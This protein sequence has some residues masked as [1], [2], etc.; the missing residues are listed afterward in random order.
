M[1]KKRFT[2]HFVVALLIVSTPIRAQDGLFISEVTDPADD[3]SGR[4]IELYNAGSEAVDFS[5]TTLYLSR[6]SNGGT[7][8][9]DLQLTG[10]IAAGE[11]FVIGGSAF[12]AVYGFAPNQETGILIGNGDDAYFL[13]LD[14]DHESGTLHDIYGL[15]DTDGSGEPWEYE[16]SRA[17]RAPA[18][19]VPNTTWTAAEWEIA[20]A[21]VAD[22]DP[23]SHHG[24]G[25][26]GPHTALTIINDTA[27]VGEPV[28]VIVSAD[29]LKATDNIISYQFDVHFNHS[30]LEYTGSQISGTL[31]EG[32]TVVVNTNIAG[33]LSVSY[34]NSAPLIGEGG[35]LKLLFNTLAP[36]TTHISLVNAY[37][38]NNPVQEI[39][40]GTVV[41]K[42]IIPPTA[43]ITYNDSIHRFAD[44]LLITATFSQPM[45]EDYVVQIS[46]SGAASLTD[47]GMIRQ[48]ETSYTYPYSIPKSEGEVLVRLGN[49]TDLWG[50]PLV[51]FPQVVTL[52]L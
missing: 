8:W 3:Y 45:S 33:S 38:N 22:C 40:N 36:D 52:F 14:G 50:N 7:G 20:F 44:T 1:M 18:V 29:M 4:F 24:S 25:I 39:N 41:I 13:Y 5:T 2:M 27:G 17:L 23:G 47:A 43:V 35:I 30:V 37:L 32:G 15:L 11:A 48:T 34:M 31:A 49:G 6:Q 16:D 12:E 28:E 9:G 26:V 10:T 46:L 42:S 51:W 19:S 21:N